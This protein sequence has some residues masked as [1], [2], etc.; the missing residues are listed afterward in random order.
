MQPVRIQRKR[1]AGYDMQAVSRATN[2]LDCIS[3]K[4]P[5]RWGNPYDVAVFGRDLSLKLFRNS[6]HGV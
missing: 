6:V 3:V 1:I 5:G 2:G 4:R